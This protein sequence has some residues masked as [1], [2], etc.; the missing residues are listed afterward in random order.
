[1]KD[2]IIDSIKKIEQSK[3]NSRIFPEKSLIYEI[4]K[5]TDIPSWHI[6]EYCKENKDIFEIIPTINNYQI[7]I[8][9]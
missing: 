6:Y 8:K 5:N 3:K 1:M 9:Q 7:L 4:S 2:V